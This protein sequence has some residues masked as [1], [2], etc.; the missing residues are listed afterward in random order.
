MREVDLEEILGGF[1]LL[2]E[3]VLEVVLGGEGEDLGVSY[4]FGV[5]YFSEVSVVSAS[6][7]FCGESSGSSKLLSDMASALCASF[8]L[9]GIG[10]MLSRAAVFESTGCATMTYP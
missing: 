5:M 3:V 8:A 6:F 7:V 2:L 4:P 1:V 10:D 9:P